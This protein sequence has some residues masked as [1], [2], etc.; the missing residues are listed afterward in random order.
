MERTFDDFL[1]EKFAS[2]I[3]GTDQDCLDDEFHDAYCGWVDRLPVENL[4]EMGTEFAR[5]EVRRVKF[6]NGLK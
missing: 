6:E 5:D 2:S 3:A 1:Q 4:I